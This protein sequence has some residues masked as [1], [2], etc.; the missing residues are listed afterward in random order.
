MP[1]PT[2]GWMSGLSHHPGKVA[3]GS[4]C[5]EFE[6]LSLRQQVLQSYNQPKIYKSIRKLRGDFTRLFAEVFVRLHPKFQLG[7]NV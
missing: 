2:E 3:Q 4:P 1:L 6:S 5:R 7:I